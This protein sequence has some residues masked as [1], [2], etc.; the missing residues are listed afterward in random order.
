VRKRAE[1]ARFLELTL[2]RRIYPA[3]LRHDPA[4]DDPARLLEANER[5]LE[6][7]HLLAE[8]SP[9]DRELCVAGTERSPPELAARWHTPYRTVNRRWHLV[10]DGLRRALE[11]WEE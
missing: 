1:K 6:L 2:G 3:Y 7:Q 5:F 4:E 9:E 8:L 11:P 10:Q